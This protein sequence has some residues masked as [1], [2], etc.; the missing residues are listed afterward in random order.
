MTNPFQ[1][2]L[3]LAPLVQ[4]FYLETNVTRFISPFTKAQQVLERAGI[5]WRCAVSFRRMTRDALR[6]EAFL[7]KMRG[8]IVEVL[9][10]DWRR[11]TPMGAFNS[12]A[13][14]YNSF[15]NATWNDG[16]TFDDGAVFSSGATGVYSDA[17]RFSNAW[18]TT[19]LGVVG[20]FPLEIIVYAGELIQTSEGR[21]SM[22]T[23]DVYADSFGTASI[24]IYPP[25]HVFS[26]IGDMVLSKMTEPRVL[27]RVIDNQ[28]QKNS[29]ESPFIANYNFELVES[30]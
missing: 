24:P 2:P 11:L 10:P 4:E 16:A 12:L 7:A 25:P 20:A 29:S 27:M 8:G 17:P 21:V 9:M 23:E 26:Y 14:Y 22:A 30:L 5:R 1:W 13:G 18:S 3:D 15:P 28:Y 6:I 19:Q